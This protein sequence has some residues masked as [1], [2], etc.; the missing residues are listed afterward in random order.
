MRS[1]Y[2]CDPGWVVHTTS[3]E[4]NMS[5]S[6]VYCFYCGNFNRWAGLGIGLPLLF[7]YKVIVSLNLFLEEGYQ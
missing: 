6:Y 5:P 1:V 3:K 7:L 4:L 2:E